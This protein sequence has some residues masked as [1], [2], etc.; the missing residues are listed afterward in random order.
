MKR[1]IGFLLVCLVLSGCG[2]VVVSTPAP[3]AT[4][5]EP[6]PEATPVPTPEYTGFALRLSDALEGRTV[7]AE[8]KV[9]DREWG[10][11]EQFLYSEEPLSELLI[12]MVEWH[13]SEENE[14]VFEEREALFYLPELAAGEAI[15]LI[16]EMP[17]VVPYLQ[18]GY[19][20]AAGDYE[21][22][23]LGYN[24]ND[25]DGG[26]ILIPAEPQLRGDLYLGEHG[27]G[28]SQVSS[29]WASK[30][31]I[32]LL[33]S[34]ALEGYVP[35]GFT[36]FDGAVADVNGDGIG[37]AAL[38]LVSDGALSTWSYH[39]DLPVHI[40]L[41]KVGGGYE[42]VQKFESALFAPYRDRCS[43]KAGEGYIE[44]HYNFTNGAMVSEIAVLRFAYDEL[45]EDW[46]LSE[47][48]YC[49]AYRP[50]YTAQ[51]PDM[52]A[53]SEHLRVSISACDVW[54]M[55]CDVRPELYEVQADFGYRYFAVNRTET[56]YEGVIYYYWE[57]NGERNTGITCTIAGDMPEGMALEVRPTEWAD[58]FYIG[59]DRWTWNREPPSVFKNLDW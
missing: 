40:L 2:G 48:G 24:Y 19:L 32:A 36:V 10:T 55:L 39:G 13:E 59:N 45:A 46:I 1:V 56:G 22:V 21:V 11:W 38:A 15:R 42:L 3:E 26:G 27:D 41:G 58:R 54:E 52:I 33:E 49:F 37:D 4:S 35:V 47:Y 28:S 25:R 16:S 20:T 29:V 5:V 18:I 23:Q 53:A 8:A 51:S 31:V 14:I 17:E 30:D 9:R 6:V 43:I 7:T 50:D 34:G 44:F 57:Y 12:S